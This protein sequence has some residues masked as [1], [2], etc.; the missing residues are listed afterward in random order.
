[1]RYSGV[2][3]Y[4]PSRVTFDCFHIP[5]TPQ[6]E[7]SLFR[8]PLGLEYLC[9]MFNDLFSLL[10]FLFY[11]LSFVVYVSYFII[12]LAL[13][14]TLCRIVSSNNLTTD[15]A[16]NV[17]YIHVVFLRPWVPTPSSLEG[18]EIVAYSYIR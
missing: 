12:L 15:V 7:W 14:S 5:L 16:V 18:V 3:Q 13:S 2:S 8:R 10:I 17:E 11:V 9:F 4:C 1:M 6:P